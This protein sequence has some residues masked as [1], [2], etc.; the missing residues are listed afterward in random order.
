M[1]DPQNDIPPGHT[2]K[3]PRSVGLSTRKTA[4]SW[5]KLGPMVWA[6]TAVICVASVFAGISS[7]P[8]DQDN[9]WMV[10]AVGAVALS[11]VAGTADRPDVDKLELS[12]LIDLGI[13]GFKYA[14]FSMIAALPGL[15]VGVVLR[16]MW[17][18][19]A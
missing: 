8:T 16:D 1:T 18:G 7:T 4:F 3:P 10:V 13:Y 11:V 6:T 5:P 17:W 19:P 9:L 15:Y 12:K 2:R 14:L